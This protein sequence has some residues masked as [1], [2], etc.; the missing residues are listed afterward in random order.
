MQHRDEISGTVSEKVEVNEGMFK[1]IDI[2]EGDAADYFLLQAKNDSMKAKTML[3]KFQ[4]EGNEPV[5][6]FVFMHTESD[7]KF[8]EFDRLQGPGDYKEMHHASTYAKIATYG[9]VKCGTVVKAQK[10]AKGYLEVV[11]KNK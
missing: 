1:V 11:A 10:N 9:P 7:L 2:L 3:K 8:R 5:V 6:V 4:M